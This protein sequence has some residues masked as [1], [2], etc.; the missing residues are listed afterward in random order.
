MRNIAVIEDE[1]VHAA[2]LEEN[3]SLYPGIPWT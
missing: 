3:L 2:K 1:D